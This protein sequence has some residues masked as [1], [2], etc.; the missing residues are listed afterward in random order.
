ML[1]ISCILSGW[2]LGLHFHLISVVLL[3]SMNSARRL[4]GL[5]L[6][7]TTRK[8]TSNTSSPIILSIQIR[9]TKTFTKVD[10]CL[11]RNCWSRIRKTSKS[12]TSMNVPRMSGKSPIKF[13]CPRAILSKSSCQHNAEK[14]S[15]LSELLPQSANVCFIIYV[16]V[17]LL[18]IL[19]SFLRV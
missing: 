6:L 1:N 2:N 11:F 16:T 3:S 12:F 14:E 7:N 17:L 8:T 13:G 18:N 19:S 4:R 5:L 9:K 15:Q 10:C